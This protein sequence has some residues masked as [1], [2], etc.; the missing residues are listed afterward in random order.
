[1][2]SLHISLNT[3][4]SGCKPSTSMSS[5]THSHQVFLFQPLH[6][7]PATSTFL[8]AD[9]Q[10]STL[11]RSRCPNHLN[12]PRLTTSTT[13]SIC[14]RC[15]YLKTKRALNS[16]LLLLLLLLLYPKDCTISHCAFCNLQRYST[17]PSHYHSLHPLQAMQIISLQCPSFQSHM[18]T[19]SGHKLCIYFPLCGM[20][21][22]G[23]PGWQ[24]L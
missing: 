17:H 12:L 14:P 18:S 8:Q 22:H 11:L 4:H 19:N 5:S 16:L 23:L 6:L 24:I 15:L 9:T 20:M 2:I 10:S 13:L 1:M 21:H 3:A 7:T